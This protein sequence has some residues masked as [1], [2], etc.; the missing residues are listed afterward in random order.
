M[1]FGRVP[2]YEDPIA[3]A[4]FGVVKRILVLRWAGNAGAIPGSLHNGI[5][6]VLTT[7]SGSTD[8][9][10]SGTLTLG[11]GDTFLGWTVFALRVGPKLENLHLVYNK[12]LSACDYYSL[13]SLNESSSTDHL[14]SSIIICDKKHSHMKNILISD[15]RAIF[16]YDYSLHEVEVPGVVIRS[17]DA[18][19]VIHYAKT[20]QY[21]SASITLGQTFTGWKPAPTVLVSF[22]ISPSSFPSILKPDVVAPG[23]LVLASWIP[24]LQD[25]QTGRYALPYNDFSILSGTSA[26][27][28][29]TAGVAA[30]LKSSHSEWSPAPI[31]ST[32]VTTANPLDNTFESKMKTWQ[33][34]PICL[35]SRHGFWSYW[36]QSSAGSGSGL[37]CNSARFIE[38]YVLYELYKE[39]NPSHHKFK[40]LHLLKRLILLWS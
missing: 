32:L 26:A 35:A 23:S 13:L 22:G 38:F 7:A 20:A 39:T 40:Q 15:L 1:G 25:V 33:R 17:K 4:S 5:L 27:C 30:L 3:I 18:S 6:W 2:L 31:K 21:P 24:N 12:T 28:S 11:N 14:N 29:H 36:S 19:E 37:W 34:L 16:V 8:R 10:F 9:W